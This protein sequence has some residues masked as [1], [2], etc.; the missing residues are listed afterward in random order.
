MINW[1]LPIIG[2]DKKSYFDCG[3]LNVDM[4]REGKNTKAN[5]E[6]TDHSEVTIVVDDYYNVVYKKL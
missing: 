2:I 4:I 5:Y 3:V 1:W 6:T